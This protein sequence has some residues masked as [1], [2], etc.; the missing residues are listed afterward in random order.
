[1]YA[2][3]HHFQEEIPLA[4]I[5]MAAALVGLMLC[6]YRG[7]SII[8][9]APFFAVVAALGSQHYGLP[10]FSELYMT[11]LADSLAKAA[12][13]GGF[14]ML[15]ET[16]LASTVKDSKSRALVAAFVFLYDDKADLHFTLTSE[17]LDFIEFLKPFVK[18][19]IDA[20]GKTYRSR[21]LPWEITVRKSG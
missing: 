14:P 11:K 5:A 13:V 19:V 1:M 7:C 17:D 3:K 15:H 18:K 16:A 8:L 12:K 20:D 21:R 6:A 2:L 4:T 9:V 10:I